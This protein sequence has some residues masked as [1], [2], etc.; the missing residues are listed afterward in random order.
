MSGL[1]TD[2][3]R[4]RQSEEMEKMVLRIRVGS[5]QGLDESP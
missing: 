1:E 3:R 2:L 4:C 5:I